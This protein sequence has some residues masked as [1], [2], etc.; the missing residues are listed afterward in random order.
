[1]KLRMFL[2]SLAVLLAAAAPASAW[3]LERKPLAGQNQLVFTSDFSA[4]GENLV[5]FLVENGAGSADDELQ[6]ANNS[7]DFVMP[8]PTG[9]AYVGGPNNVV[10]CLAAGVQRMTVFFSWRDDFWKSLNTTIPTTVHGDS[11]ND[12]FDSRDAADTLL[13]QAGN[14]RIEDNPDKPDRDTIDGGAGDDEI[15]NGVGADDIRGGEGIDSVVLGST[16]DDVTLDDVANDGGASGEGDNIRSDVENLDGGGGNDVL[17]G[18]AD[19]NRLEG[20]PGTDELRGGGGADDLIGDKGADA[21]FGGADFDR[22]TYPELPT[23]ALPSSADQQVSLDD[24]ADDG[25]QGEGDNVHSD[26]EDVFAGA[27][28]DTVSGNDN[29]NVLDGGAGDDTV[30]GGGG[31]DTLFGGAGL[32]VMLA[33]DGLPD[34]VECNADGGSATVDITDTVLGCAP[35]DASDALIPDVDG[36]GSAK[37]A[38]CDDH[39]AAIRPGATDIF[40]NGIDEDCNG[41]DAVNLDRDADGFTRPGDCDDANRTVHPG[42]REI[43]GNKIDEDCSGSAQPFPQ[44]ASTVRS[45]FAF[46]PLRF[47]TLTIV[48]AVKGSRIELRCRGGGCFRRTRLT[49]RK[50]RPLLSLKRHVRKARLR[51]GA[52]VEIRITKANHVGVMRRVTARG[53][54]RTPKIQD[55]CLPAGGGKPRR[56]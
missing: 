43:V 38:D 18:D 25:V 4:V 52:V 31:A 41:S 33:R 37:P 35:V 29:P 40:E 44:I 53:A 11:G 28:R 34:R 24:V 19:A 30:T 51:K 46:P 10:E 21:L 22:V 13:G 55:F 45:F 36:D 47:T 20:G 3:K 17:T 23:M 42:A 54:R 5:V 56:C 7:D 26:V 14:D 49:V 12:W 6:F 27:G 2:L 39:N 50:S 15:V 48:R 32:D 1:M 8:L 9:C 16:H